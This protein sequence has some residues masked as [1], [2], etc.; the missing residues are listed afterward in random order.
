MISSKGKVKKKC[1]AAKLIEWGNGIIK[2][3]TSK[4]GK[5]REEKIKK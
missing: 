5:K 4:Q 1:I 2:I 3:P